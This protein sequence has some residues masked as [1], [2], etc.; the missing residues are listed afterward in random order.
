[1]NTLSSIIGDFNF[2]IVYPVFITK[3]DNVRADQVKRVTLG[4]LI[5]AIVYS[6]KK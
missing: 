6:W 3:C 4:S 2:S 1:M 5:K